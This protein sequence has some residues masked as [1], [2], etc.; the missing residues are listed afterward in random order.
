MPEALNFVQDCTKNPGFPG[1]SFYTWILQKKK[2]H[3]HVLSGFL[4]PPAL[5]SVSRIS[6]GFGQK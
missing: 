3:K 5:N 1:I 2:K 4:A 6:G